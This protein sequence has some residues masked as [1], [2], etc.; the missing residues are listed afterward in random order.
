MDILSQV[1]KPRAAYH[2]FTNNMQDYLLTLGTVCFLG[3]RLVSFLG[4]DSASFPG[5]E[6]IRLTTQN[7]FTF[8]DLASAISSTHSLYSILRDGK[9]VIK[10][11][12]DQATIRAGR[13][14]D[15]PRGDNPYIGAKTWVAY[16]STSALFKTVSSLLLVHEACKR[17]GVISKSFSSP[18]RAVGSG[19]GILACGIDI[20]DTGRAFYDH[21]KDVN[22][23]N[24][25]TDVKIASIAP[26]DQARAIN[27]GDENLHR[28][29]VQKSRIFDIALGALV[30]GIKILGSIRAFDVVEGAGLAGR[31]SRFAAKHAE[32]VYG[33]IFTMM[34]VTGFVQHMLY[35]AT[36]QQLEQRNVN[37][38]G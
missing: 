37:K 2:Y 36:I 16:K 19:L 13:K 33:V 25:P 26:K 24:V 12:E 4:K 14:G 28:D 6:K 23:G 17:L 10:G 15:M 35:G 20:I 34:N 9:R 29:H 38:R 22:D 7:C 1:S 18:V 31:V 27:A 32:N 5:L 8:Y 21:R 30:I 11:G 3:K